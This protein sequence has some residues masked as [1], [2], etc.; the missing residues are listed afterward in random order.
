LC[1]AEEAVE[2]LEGILRLLLGASVQVRRGGKW[3]VEL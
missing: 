3:G 1:P 2:E